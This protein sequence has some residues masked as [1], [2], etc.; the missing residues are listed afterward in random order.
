MVGRLLHP[1]Y[2][3]GMP[4]KRVLRGHTRIIIAKVT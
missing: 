1:R 4:F 3:V 2:G